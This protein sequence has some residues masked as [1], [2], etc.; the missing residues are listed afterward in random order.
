[1]PTYNIH[2]FSTG[3]NVETW[4]DGSWISRGYKVGEYMNSTLSQ[5]PLVVQRAIANKMFEVSKDSHS[6]K[7]TF[8]G[9]EVRGKNADPAWSVVAVVTP[10]SDDYGL[11]NS[12]YRYILCQGV[13]RLWVILDAIDNYSQKY[14]RLPIFNPSEIKEI[15][16]PNYHNISN[17]PLVTLPSEL[18]SLT[19]NYQ[20]ALILQPGQVS[21]LQTINAVAEKIANGQLVSW[22]YD[23]EAVERA[24]RFL[25]IQAADEKAYQDL[26]RIGNASIDNLSSVDEPSIEL[27]IKG[28]IGGSQIKQ[29][30]IQ[31]LLQNEQVTSDHCQT[32][33]DDQGAHTR[34]KQ[35]NYS[36]QMVRLLTLR[37]IIIP[38]TLPEYLEWFGIDGKNK[39]KGDNKQK[40]SLEFQGQLKK[41]ILQ[42][43][44][45]ID[46]SM[47]SVL[48]QIL[49]KKISIPAFSWL[50]TA[51][52]SLWSSY[53]ASLLQNVRDDLEAI[54]NYLNSSDDSPS[55]PS[56]ACGDSIWKNL[57]SGLPGPN[58]RYSYYQPFADL[59][60]RLGDYQLAS[61]FY[62][63]SKGVV[64]KNLFLKAFKNKDKSD[65]WGLT[66]NREV[67]W[68]EHLIN[69][70][71]RYSLSLA[72]IFI[73]VLTNLF[74]YMLGLQSKGK[75]GLKNSNGET[76]E[77]AR[78]AGEQEGYDK[79]YQVG[80]QEG[81]NAAIQVEI[82]PPMTKASSEFSTTATVMEAL[83]K[84]LTNQ[85][86]EKFIQADPQIMRNQVIKE[87]KTIIGNPNLDYS[88]AI[89][90]N[91]NYKKQLIEAIYWYQANT[92][93]KGYGYIDDNFETDE[94]IEKEVNNTLLFNFANRTKPAL[95]KL[96]E[97]LLQD[98]SLRQKNIDRI[99]IINAIKNTFVG[100]K[101]YT[102]TIEEG[103]PKE[104]EKFVNSIQQY[105]NGGDGIINYGKQTY[106][107]LKEE[108]KTQYEERFNFANKTK[109]ALEKLIEELLEDENLRQEKFDR[110]QIIN[111]I[112][113]TFV[114]ITDY[115]GAIEKGN[116][117][118]VEKFVN[119]IREYQNGGD[120]IIHYSEETYQRLKQDIQRQLLE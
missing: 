6:Q 38:D 10:G 33:F 15:G 56:F 77:Q 36:P 108:I 71:R 113:N 59:F 22:A 14:G 16:K 93:E 57:Q 26:I 107:R 105:Q 74:S 83:V 34:I 88:S 11:F 47:K 95:E 58:Y 7:P 98:N 54:D 49:K 94:R 102:A 112:K 86:T 3:I 43:E 44:P 76:L 1:M 120:G 39:G 5:I 24:R 116:P 28:L 65:L 117:Q 60:E 62:Q 29:E 87:I 19:S 69:L 52:K 70:L 73:L 25:V 42:L 104:V 17:K 51:Q 31:A 66:L 82:I 37:A 97:E 90:G 21:D 101:D 12:F 50:L 20:R 4:P 91:E 111:A 84:R 115:A 9:R 114:G 118:E 67:T 35:R 30:W 8:V 68:D 63:V 80:Y 23:V 110:N 18:N 75:I 45:L 89:Q 100:I 46:G 103:K 2:E 79:G 96:I 27:A 64:P 85:L 53:R 109:P 32:I 119:S 40:V 81:L 48:E 13:D 55:E 61:Y 78:E 72:A 41:H 92:G 99:Q 106:Q